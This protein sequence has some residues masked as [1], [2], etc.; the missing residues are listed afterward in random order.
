MLCQ[1][2]DE[3]EAGR[4]CR[5]DSWPKLTKGI[6]HTIWHHAQHINWGELVG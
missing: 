4:E 2:G 6:F 5:Q 1:R 3:Q